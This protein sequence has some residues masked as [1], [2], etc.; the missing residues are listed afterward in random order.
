MYWSY[1]KK[2]IGAIVGFCSTAIV[3]VEAATADLALVDNA[4]KAVLGVFS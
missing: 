3:V 1:R 4:L 2:V